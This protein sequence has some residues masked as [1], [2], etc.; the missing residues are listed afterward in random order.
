MTR[1]QAPSI[2][3][4]LLEAEVASTKHSEFEER[5]SRATGQTVSPGRPSH[6][7]DQPNKWGAEL[8]VYFNDAD[9]AAKLSA[10]GMNVENRVTGYLSGAYAY[11]VNDNDYW[12]QLVERDGLRLGRN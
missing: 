4:V 10:R 8:R 1:S 11:R 6:Y 5:Y 2:R 3:D 12:W 7:Q 9:L